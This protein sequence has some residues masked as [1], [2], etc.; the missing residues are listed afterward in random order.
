MA[1]QSSRFFIAVSWVRAE[2]VPRETAKALGA[3]KFR[4]ST[5]AV[6]RKKPRNDRG[7]RSTL[8]G[9]SALLPRLVPRLRG[10]C[11]LAVRPGRLVVLLVLL[12]PVALLAGLTRL[13]A[14]LVVLVASPC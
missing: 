13:L 7:L 5:L 1:E 12:V 8:A 6:G 3:A 4:A 11:R 10:P 9:L 2:K 14:L